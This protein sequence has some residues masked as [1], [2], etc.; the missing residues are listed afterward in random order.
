MTTIANIVEIPNP[1]NSKLVPIQEVKTFLY[2][3]L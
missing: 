2:L 1:I 3:V